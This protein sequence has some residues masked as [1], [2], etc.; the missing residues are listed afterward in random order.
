[1]AHAGVSGSGAKPVAYFVYVLQNADGRRYVGQTA[2]PVRRLAEHNHGRVT[3]TK[4]RGPWVMV[5]HTVFATRLQ[6]IREERR[7]KRNWASLDRVI[8]RWQSAAGAGIPLNGRRP[9]TRVASAA[10]VKRPL[11][12]KRARPR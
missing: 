6:A 4:S 12:P 8:S 9:A 2:D 7:L 1:M 11:P 3:W 10:T 5:A